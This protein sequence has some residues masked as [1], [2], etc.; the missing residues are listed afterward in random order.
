VEKDGVGWDLEAKGEDG[1]V[2]KIEVKG[3]SGSGVTVELTPNDYQMMISTEHRADY[4]VYVVREA[5]S[6]KPKSSIFR[7][8]AILSKG[9]DLVWVTAEGQRLKITPLTAAQLTIA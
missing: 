4:I 6:S 7:H 2:L 9:K 8:D 5:L 1:S 3:L